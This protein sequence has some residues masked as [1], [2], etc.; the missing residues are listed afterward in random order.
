ML[1]YCLYTDDLRVAGNVWWLQ[2]VKARLRLTIVM[3]PY[4]ISLALNWLKRS[5]CLHYCGRTLI[6]WKCF[7]FAL[8]RAVS[9]HVLHNVLLQSHSMVQSICA[10][11]SRS[12]NVCVLPTHPIEHCL[13]AHQN[14]CDSSTSNILVLVHAHIT[15]YRLYGYEY[16]SLELCY[17]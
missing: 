8:G 13:Y 14:Y 1:Y 5:I 17:M 3:F 6:H 16:V 7:Y 4:F 11:G 12:P 2:L 15:V 9:L 10:A